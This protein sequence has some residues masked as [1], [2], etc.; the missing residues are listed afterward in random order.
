MIDHPHIDLE[1]G[2]D[3]FERR[4]RW[5]G[6]RTIYS[7]PIDRFF[8][9]AHGRLDWRTMRFE[10]ENPDC[11]DYQG[12]AV[13]NSA[14]LNVEYTRVHEFKHLHPERP[15]TGKTTIY[16]EFSQITGTNDEPYYPV[17]T[18]RNTELL[19]T[20]MGLA[21]AEKDVIFGGRLGSYRYLNM[22]QTIRAALDTASGIA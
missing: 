16:R 13:I 20:Y 10:K 15:D 6:M 22:D 17:N 9:D 1:L 2:T 14:D 11:S 3:Y 18:K 12:S 5:S 7:G 8:N 4:D 19:K 21:R